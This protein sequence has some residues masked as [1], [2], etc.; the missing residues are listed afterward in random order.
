MTA[1]AR[2]LRGSSAGLTGNANDLMQGLHID[3]AHVPPLRA[4]RQRCD[5]DV[6]VRTSY[7]E[8][9]YSRRRL[10]PVTELVESRGPS[11]GQRADSMLRR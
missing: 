10:R 1:N 11:T 6:Y 4:G 9:T 3:S 7:R 8:P 5:E 2:L